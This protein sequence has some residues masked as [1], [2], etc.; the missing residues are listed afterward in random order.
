MSGPMTTS[1]LQPETLIPAIVDDTVRGA[2]FWEPLLDGN[3]F[4][5]RMPGG[6]RNLSLQRFDENTLAFSVLERTGDLVQKWSTDE[7]P[8]LLEPYRALLAA[9]RER[10]T[11]TSKAAEHLG[12]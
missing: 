2:I 5:A 10:L 9:I 7:R 11:V 8:A 3:L 4:V 6:S 12:T 1:S